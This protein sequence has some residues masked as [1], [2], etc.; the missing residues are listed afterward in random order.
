MARLHALGRAHDL[1]TSKNW[2]SGAPLGA[3]VDHALGPFRCKGRKRITVRV[4]DVWLPANRSLSLTLALHELA[5]NAAKYGALSNGTGRVSV[6]WDLIG[7]AEGRK[8]TMAR[9]KQAGHQ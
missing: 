9:R 5:T 6:S 8:V 7:K 2:G 4:P 1:L 3:V